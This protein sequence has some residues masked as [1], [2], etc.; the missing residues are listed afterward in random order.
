MYT[1]TKNFSIF[2]LIFNVLVTP[3]YEN[4][5]VKVSEIT[6]ICFAFLPEGWEQEQGDQTWK[7]FFV[8]AVYIH[9]FAVY[10]HLTEKTDGV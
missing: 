4:L 2:G 10:I 6:E 5:S 1:F 8:F 3:H 7:K 9:M